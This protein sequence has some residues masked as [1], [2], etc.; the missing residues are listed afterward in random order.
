MLSLFILVLAA[1]ANLSGLAIA[2]ITSEIS[3]N[4]KSG[5]KQHKDAT[6][7]MN[8]QLLSTFAGTLLTARMLLPSRIYN[9]SPH[10]K[11]PF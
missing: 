2:V 4:E 8:L 9:S 6:T 11:A 7:F 3:L 5:N 1:I 10:L